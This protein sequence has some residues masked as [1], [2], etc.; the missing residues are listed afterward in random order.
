MAVGAVSQRELPL[1]QIIIGRQVLIAGSAT[2]AL[3]QITDN[4]L[5][6][7]SGD[8]ANV[9]GILQTVTTNGTGFVITSS[10]GG[11]VGFVAYMVVI[12]P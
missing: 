4:S 10:V 3:K 8:D 2:V 12:I 9:D 11:D 5:I 7:V 6:F 1:T